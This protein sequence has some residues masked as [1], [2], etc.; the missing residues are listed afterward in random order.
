MAKQGWPCPKHGGDEA[1]RRSLH[2][3]CNGPGL[4]DQ[5][6]GS[7]ERSKERRRGRSRAASSGPACPPRRIPAPLTVVGLGVHRVDPQVLPEKCHR[8]VLRGPRALPLLAGCH[9]RTA[10]PRRKRRLT[11]PPPSAPRPSEAGRGK[12]RPLGRNGAEAGVGGPRGAAGAAGGR[13]GVRAHGAEAGRRNEGNAAALGGGGHEERGGAHG[14]AVGVRGT[15]RPWS[16]GPITGLRAGVGRSG[17]PPRPTPPAPGPEPPPPPALPPRRR[18]CRSAPAPPPRPRSAPPRS[19]P[20]RPEALGDT[21]QSGARCLLAS[22]QAA[23]TSFLPARRPPRPR[24]AR[25]HR[26]R[27][28]AQG[29]APPERPSET[30]ISD[31][32]AVGTE[33]PSHPPKAAGTAPKLLELRERLVIALSA[34][35]VP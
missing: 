12:V 13:R 35:V 19:I 2:R 14:P 31:R 30:P 23:R 33:Q 32:R 5:A 4:E 3:D 22:G 34:C 7:K 25:Q 9:S 21:A 24:P 20:L 16:R 27:S 8:R 15:G 29:A 18:R 10:E 1:P 26:A 6:R 17:P 11:P 28:P